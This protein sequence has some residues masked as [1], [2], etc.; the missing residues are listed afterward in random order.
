MSLDKR[1]KPR[2]DGC[3]AIPL[4]HRLHSPSPRLRGEG[5]GEGPNQGEGDGSVPICV[6][7]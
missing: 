3:A 6:H 4:S 2:I 7:P 1:T 5:W